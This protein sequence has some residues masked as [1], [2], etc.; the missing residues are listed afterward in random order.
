MFP[1]S[2]HQGALLTSIRIKSFSLKY[3]TFKL[4]SLEQAL[5]NLFYK[6][7]VENTLGSGGNH[8]SLQLQCKITMDNTNGQRLC[9]NKVLFTKI[10]NGQNLV[11]GSQLP[12]PALEKHHFQQARLSV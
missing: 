5:A 7:Q 12:T 10:G 9:S 8:L 2:P 1:N 11:S 4:Y 6:D 3:E